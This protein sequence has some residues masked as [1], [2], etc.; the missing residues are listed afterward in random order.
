[1]PTPTNLAYL[2][3]QGRKRRFS[4]LGKLPHESYVLAL[5][6]EKAQTLVDFARGVLPTFDQRRRTR[7]ARQLT[8]SLA[9]LIR[10]LHERSL[11][12]RDLK[13][14]N[15][16]IL[17]QPDDPN[18]ELTLIDLV[19]VDLRYPVPRRRIVQNLARLFLSLQETPNRTRSDYLRFLKSYLPWAR[20]G[21]DTWKSLWREVEL[22]AGSKRR[23]NERRGRIL[24]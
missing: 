11:S 1:V 21:G 13:A 4:L 2:Q 24:S 17:G 18:P 20:T 6:A 12:H 16:L 8:R 10:T 9:R 15:I 7:V 22:A 23:Q 19:G 3:I 5:K 14:A